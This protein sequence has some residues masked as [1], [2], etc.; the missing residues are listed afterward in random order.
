MT[1]DDLTNFYLQNRSQVVENKWGI[2]EPQSGDPVPTSKIDL[3][4][5]PLLAYDNDGHRVGYGKG[6]YDRFLLCCR[7]DCKKIGL[8]FFDPAEI[9]TDAAT[10][11]IR[12]DA[13]VTPTKSFSFAN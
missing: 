8:S 4:V 7:P 5:V 10:H 12:L 11:D 1:G 9:I 6:F 2:P 13:V 3:V